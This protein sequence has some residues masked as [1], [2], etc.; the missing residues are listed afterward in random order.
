MRA[1]RADDVLAPDGLFLT[2]TAQD[3]RDGLRVLLERDQLHPAADSTAVLLEVLGDP[4]LD[5]ERER[6]WRV[7]LLEPLHAQ[8]AALGSQR[9]E[10]VE[11]LPF[12][13]PSVDDPEPVK[14]LERARLDSG[15]PGLWVRRRIALDETEGD[16]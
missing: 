16:A 11:H 13:E 10:C 12:A 9:P 4:L 3:G 8:L 2:P 5:V 14:D 6:V 7:E 1:V 15:R